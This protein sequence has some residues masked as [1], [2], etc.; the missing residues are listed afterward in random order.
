MHCK[1]QSVSRATVVVGGA[2][3]T[4]KVKVVGLH[5]E[6]AATAGAAATISGTSTPTL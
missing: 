4:Q 1:S 2:A 3:E 5:F 6:E